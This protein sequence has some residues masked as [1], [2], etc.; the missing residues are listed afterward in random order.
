MRRLFYGLLAAV[1][2]GRLIE[3]RISRRHRADL[4]ARGAAPAADPVFPWI[5]ALHVAVI[6]GAGV[7][8][9][10]LRRRF[11]PALGIPML[12]LVCGATLLRWWVIRTLGAHWNVRVMDSAALGVVTKG[13]YRWVRH[14]NYL[15]VLVELCALPLVHTAWITALVGSAAHLLVLRRRI[16]SE[17]AVLSA[18]PI[19]RA[20]MGPKP[21]L[22]PLRI[23]A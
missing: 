5:V 19:W 10:A 22:F 11:I 2:A 7:E 17:E 12:G 14:P 8:V 6:A 1:T 18:D 15:A 4:A 16:A 23:G 13:P 3:L 9:S 20:E 21:R